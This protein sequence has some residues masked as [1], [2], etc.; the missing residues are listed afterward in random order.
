ML[1]PIVEQHLTDAAFLWLLRDDAA[2]ALSYR[3]DE[4][5][6]LDE[7]VEAHV[8]A[9]R[10]AGDE[11]FPLCDIVF[12]YSEAGELFAAGQLALSTRNWKQFGA[13]LNRVGGRPDLARGVVSALGWKPDPAVDEAL[14]AMNDEQGPAELHA[15]GLSAS[16]VAGRDPGAALQRALRP[17]VAPLRIQGYRTA[18][19]LGRSDLVGDIYPGLAAEHAEV[20]LWAAWALTLLGDLSAQS[21]LWIEAEKEGPLANVARRL[22]LHLDE[23]ARARALLDGLKANPER[24]RD[25]VAAVLSAG[26]TA[27]LPWLLELL[28]NPAWARLAAAT[29]A[30]LLAIDLAAEDA[31]AVAPVDVVEGPSDDA[32]DDDVALDPDREL[33]WP[34]AARLTTLCHERSSAL[35]AGVRYLFGQPATPA[36]AE[37]VYRRGSQ[38][39]RREAALELALSSPDAPLLNPSAP[40]LAVG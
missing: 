27:S 2:R 22:V 29:I 20:E 25:A 28:P 14:A 24:R 16:R 19:C 35:A 4:L 31:E 10:V 15:L 9:L 1:A 32:D 12:D 34:D 30:S 11:A 5:A 38:W 33:V 3:R 13:L 36:H 18:A 39:L 8:D 7:R 21:R 40:V 17:S 6:E 23:P 26:D 37:E